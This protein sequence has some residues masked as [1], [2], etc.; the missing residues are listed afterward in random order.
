M[1]IE[2][3]VERLTKDAFEGLS[4]EAEPLDPVLKGRAIELWCDPLAD[5]LWVVADEEDAARLAEPRG[6][7]YSLA[8]VRRVVRITDAA[9]VRQVHA[10]KRNFD[11][12][13]RDVVRE[14]AAIGRGRA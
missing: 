4:A 12:R 14:S 1:D 7:V 6:C 2:R 3:Y 8:E 5:T 9:V 11:G 13:V 10:F